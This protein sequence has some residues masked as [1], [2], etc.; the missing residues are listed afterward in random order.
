M[1]YIDIPLSKELL[2]HTF[3]LTKNLTLII[4]FIALLTFIDF[5]VGLCDTLRNLIILFFSLLIM[6]E[7]RMIFFYLSEIG[8]M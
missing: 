6:Y 1:F 2:R 8:T 5:L 7:I 4:F 3:F